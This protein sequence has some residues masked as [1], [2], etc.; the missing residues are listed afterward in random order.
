LTSQPPA[1]QAPTYIFGVHIEVDLGDNQIINGN[2]SIQLEAT[3]DVIQNYTFS[4]SPTTGLSDTTLTPWASPSVTTT[5][6]LT[7][8][9]EEGCVFTDEIIVSVT[10]TD[11]VVAVPSAF[12]PNDDSENDELN[13]IIQ[14]NYELTG[15][16]I[17]NRWGEEIFFTDNPNTGWD[18]T[19]NGEKQPVGT[20]VYI[21]R[22]EDT[23]GAK[24]EQGGDVTLLR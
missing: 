3:I 18:G 2:D 24:T 6:T 8:L 5:Y 12:T 16:H 19:Y 1:E 22:Y 9:S 11:P 13:V 17:F 23:S 4:W 21:V 14:G 20:Y 10:S 15:F 7:V